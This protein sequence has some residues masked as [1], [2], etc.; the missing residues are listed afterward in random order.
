MKVKINTKNGAKVVNINRR[1]AIKEKV[2]KL[3]GMGL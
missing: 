3:F 1:K 2:P